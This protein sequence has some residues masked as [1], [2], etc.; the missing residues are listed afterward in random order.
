MFFWGRRSECFIT[1]KDGFN[2][3][4]GSLGLIGLAFN[5]S[6]VV[7]AAIR[8][9]PGAAK[10]DPD[11]ILEACLGSGRHLL[12]TTLTTIGSFLPL[13]IFIGGEFW[14]P[15]AVVLAGGAGG[16]TLLALFFTPAAYVAMQR[17]SSFRFK[18]LP[19]KG[20]GFRPIF[21]FQA[22]HSLHGS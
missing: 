21:I 15:L 1:L 6:I 20:K 3:M 13:L 9:H 22:I 11:A 8:A 4:I 16:S 14:P 18:P 5:S 17:V 2:T 12:S 7:L 10:G 19:Q